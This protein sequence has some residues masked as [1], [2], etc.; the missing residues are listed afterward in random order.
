M[1]IYTDKVHIVSDKSVEEL[2]TFAGYV[3][4]KRNYFHNRRGRNRPHY[5]LPKT[6]HWIKLVRAKA[7]RCSTRN[8]VLAL[9]RLR[10]QT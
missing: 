3:G 5:D 1:T 9:R 10:E 6:I 7:I 8:I 2:H 4:I